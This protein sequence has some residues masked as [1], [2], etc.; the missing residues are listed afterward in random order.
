MTNSKPKVPGEPNPST[1]KP[2]GEETSSQRNDPYAPIERALGAVLHLMAQNAQCS[3]KSLNELYQRVLPAI[4][5]KQFRLVRNDDEEVIAYASWALASPET[6][7]KIIEGQEALRP[8]DWQSGT[9]AFLIDLVSLDPKLS[10][11][12]VHRLKK[13]VFPDTVFKAQRAVRGESANPEW[14]EVEL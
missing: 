13:E 11:G 12:F 4:V 1:A 7:K 14:I 8:S 9:S 3:G 10:A 2:N 6:E 5:T